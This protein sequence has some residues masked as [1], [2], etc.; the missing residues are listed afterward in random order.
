MGAGSY[1]WM[2]IRDGGKLAEVFRVQGSLCGGWKQS[3][4]S[5]QELRQN[6]RSSRVGA[7]QEALPPTSSPTLHCISC[8][9]FTGSSQW[10]KC[11]PM[12]VFWKGMRKESERGDER[13]GGV[14]TGGDAVWGRKCFTPQKG[15]EQEL[16]NLN[17]FGVEEQI[18][19]PPVFNSPNR[20]QQCF[21]RGELIVSGG[22]MILL[23]FWF[24]DLRTVRIFWKYPRWYSGV[25]LNLEENKSTVLILRCWYYCM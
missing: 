5:R 10:K 1:R 21:T 17:S 18:Y 3:S 24:T 6:R 11:E 2:W 15:H 4:E 12:W 20:Q 23:R 8:D 25:F 16:V 9:N 13:V 19:S 14:C 7:G 22:M